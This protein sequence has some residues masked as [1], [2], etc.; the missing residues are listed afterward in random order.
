MC[1]HFAFLFDSLCSPL[2]QP[3]LKTRALQRLMK[4]KRWNHAAIQEVAASPYSL[5][6]RPD[7]DQVFMKDP[8]IQVEKAHEARKRISRDIRLYK[9][10]FEEHVSSR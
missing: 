8:S 2:Q 3:D 7:A 10:D 1:I 5:Y 9:R 6:K 4:D